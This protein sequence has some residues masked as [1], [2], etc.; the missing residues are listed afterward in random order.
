VVN[1]G[2]G[3]TSSDITADVACFRL[4]GTSTDSA[5]TAVFLTRGYNSGTIG[6]AW[7]NDPTATDYTPETSYQSSG[8]VTIH[9]A[10]VGDYAVRFPGLDAAH[11]DVEIT[12]YGSLPCKVKG[13]T[14]D[15]TAMIVGVLCPL[16]DAQFNILY[17]KN[18]GLTGVVRPKAA[19]LHAF[20]F[21]TGANR[22]PAAFRYSTAGTTPTLTRTSA[23]RYVVTLPGMPK[24]GVVHVTAGFNSY[25][26]CNVSKI[27]TIGTPQKVGVSCFIA[28]SGDP[29]DSEFGLSYTK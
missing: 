25:Y 20:P 5:F 1:W 11:G 18:V 27:R 6:Y 10:G 29:Q 19:Y 22:L 16:G 3:P 9:R 24:G 28:I 13:I 7:A 4:N 8:S 2:A 21:A 23:G 26:L 17:T 15:S 14:A 12:G